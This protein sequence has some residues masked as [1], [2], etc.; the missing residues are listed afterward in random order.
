MT[1]IPTAIR[2]FRIGLAASLLCTGLL[3]A[4]ARPGV[5]GEIA[6]MP[7]STT[8]SPAQGSAPATHEP[9]P[10]TSPREP[11]PLGTVGFG[12]G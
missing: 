5:A 12:W 10:A 4:T 2:F 6:P 1:S 11:C 3:T 9:T 7:V 8:S